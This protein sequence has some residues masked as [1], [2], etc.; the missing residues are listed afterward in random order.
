MFP[1]GRD[2][3]DFAAEIESH[4]Q[5]EIDRLQQE[6]L[7]ADEARAAARRAFGNVARSTERFHESHRWAWWDRLMQDVRYAV[8]SWRTAPGLTLV[9][10]LTTALGIGAT[11]ATFSVVDATLLH[12]LPY[13]HADRLVS[14]VDDLPGIASYD[15]GVSQPEW[16][17]LDRSGIFD[18]VALA[19]FDENNLTGA[20]RPSQ[21]RLMSVTPNYFAVLGVA[22]QLGRTFPAENRSPGYLGEIVISD[23]L[24]KGDFGGDPH[25]LDK[26]IRLDTDLYRIVGVMPPG[27]HAPG[28]TVD[29]R[30]VDV[31]AATSFY[32]PPLPYEPP[33]RVR[34]VPDAIARLGPDQT[35]AA[36]QGRINALVGELRR[37]YPDDYPERA[38]WTVRL[39][40]LQDTV[41]G[42][43]RGSLILMLCAVGLVM[44]ISCVNV[45]N[46]LL[47]RAST[48]RREFAVRQAIGAGSS[49]LMRQ[50]LTES[51]CLSAVGGAVGVAFLFVAKASL[52]RLI[53]AGLPRL[54]EI[55][56]NWSVLL[57]AALVT[58]ASGI[59]FGCAPAIAARRPAVLPALH[60][61]SRGT[62]SSR[63]QARTRSTLVVAEFAL[64]IVLM[65]AAG[66]LLRSFRDLLTVQLGFDPANVVTV[67][68]RLPYPN[69]TSIDKYPT[70]QKEAPFLRELLRRLGTI[71]GV[72]RAAIASSSAIPLDHAHRDMNVVPL[73]VEGRGVD[74]AQAPVVDDS[75]VTPEY[76]QLLGMTALRGRLFTDF[77]NEE[78]PPVAVINEAMARTFWPDAD[79][80]G[81]HVKLSRS[82]KAWTM[83]V[84]I[85]A[86]AHTESL[87]DAGVPQ[88][89]ASAYQKT[90]KHLAIFLRGPVDT[91]V[92][93]ERVREIVQSLDATLPVFGAAPL[94]SAVSG[95]LA[96]RRFAMQIV[97]LFAITALLLAAL[98][99]YGVMSYTITARTQEIG[100]RLALGAPRERVFAE[101]I[102]DGLALAV[103]GTVAGVLCAV[104]VARLMAGVLY[105]IRPLDPMT[106]AGVPAVLVIVAALACS[107]PA[108]RALRIEPLLA[109]RGD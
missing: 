103:V 48:R 79:P 60:T 16:L 77:D 86:D 3:D 44:L 74:A 39:V 84:G 9:A 36:A 15:V 8:R 29:E 87:A 107:V 92:T 1:R 10:I 47:A 97:G 19:W 105:G 101:I 50:V 73:L 67:R 63:H 49:R 61:S 24:W 37:E 18:Q 43:V 85:I 42:D 30:N 58:V 76:F 45:A 52:V 33:R 25:I 59:V 7:G 100:I 53:P 41:V 96:A 80:I 12:P 72:E 88:V 106:F 99:I 78:A 2:T 75:V 57:F 89:Y 54:N 62:S 17:D 65:I 6:G 55:A 81:E 34:N 98:G 5:F 108:R 32:G 94:N 23:G 38:G 13:P 4:L 91:P 26:S 35:L 66:L 83:I 104:V 46:L 69:D 56:L 22:A 71:P 70:A 31:W 40:P 51:L 64:S 93:A 14:V 11:T 27:F 20:S 21:V 102:R 82:A 90:S 68:T 95:S 28:R 109:L